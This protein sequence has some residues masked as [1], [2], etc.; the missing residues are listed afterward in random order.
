VNLPDNELGLSSLDELIDWTKTYIHFKQAL[1]VVGRAPEL[2]EPYFSA[3][4]PFSRRFCEE[5]AKQ[6]RLEL[7]LPKEMRESIASEKPY[8]IIIRELLQSHISNTDALE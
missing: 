3:F 1:E 4:E 7:R 6:E 8:L 5:I 2:A